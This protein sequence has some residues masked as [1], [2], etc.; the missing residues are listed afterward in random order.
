M[1]FEVG[2][3]MEQF[4]DM[5]MTSSQQAY[6][7]DYFKQQEADWKALLSTHPDNQTLISTYGKT[8]VIEMCREK[9]KELNDEFELS[10]KR[11]S[12]S[13]QYLE[14]RNFCGKDRPIYELYLEYSENHIQKIK[15]QLDRFSILYLTA[16]NRLPKSKSGLTDE[17]ISTARAYSSHELYSGKLI[18]SGHNWKC[19]CPFHEERTPSFYFYTEE[20]S[21]YCFGCHAGGGNA[22]DYLMKAENLP[23]KEAVG[24]LI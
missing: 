13:K 21:W 10:D 5:T 23:F 12:K 11:Y 14:L 18:R 8:E 6:Q 20:N 3:F 9:I 15:K 24:R 22:I 1:V 17:Q 2:F 7:E 19:L 4:M 16:I